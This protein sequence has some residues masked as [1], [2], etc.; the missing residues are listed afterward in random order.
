MKPG[1]TEW[2]ELPSVIERRGACDIPQNILR[3]MTT[4]AL[5]ETV[6]T[7]PFFADA[8]VCF[9]SFEQ[10]LNWVA[11][12]FSGIDELLSRTDVSVC[13]REYLISKEERY[14]KLSAIELKEKTTEQISEW[15]Y[16][17]YAKILL[18][19][20]ESQNPSDDV[21][22]GMSRAYNVTIHTPKNSNVSVVAG[23][24]WSDHNMDY[25]RAVQY[26]KMAKEN[27]PSATEVYPNSCNP[28]YNCH[29]YAWYSQLSSNTY[30]ISNPGPYVTDG[31]YISSFPTS[32]C[33][34]LYYCSHKV[35]DCPYYSNPTQAS[36]S[37]WI[38]NP[39]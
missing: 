2:L 7:Y 16:Y 8:V 32:G 6:I 21:R 24:T 35:D 26:F 27:Y 1:T 33:K 9:E 31:S 19:Y 4:S 11:T 30:W 17:E 14:N 38:P 25:A 3:R 37:Y 12:Y 10:G 23:Y 13:L 20:I 15:C 36:I 34:I 39:N 5:V 22:E 28:G 29:S 18:Q